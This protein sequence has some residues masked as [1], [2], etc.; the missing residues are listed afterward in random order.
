VPDQITILSENRCALSRG[1]IAE[2]GFSALVELEGFK[3]LFDTGQGMALRQNQILGYDL[4]RIDALVLS[5][6]H[7][8]HTGGIGYVLEKNPEIKIYLHPAALLKRKARKAMAGKEIEIEVGMPMSGA[9]MEALG[10]ELILIEKRRELAEGRIL[11]SGPIPFRVDF[12]KPEEGFFVEQDGRLIPDDFAD[13]LAIAVKGKK[14]DTSVIFGCAHRG[15]INTLKQIEA[16][17]GMKKLDAV[18][19]GMHLFSRSPEQVEQT[20]NELARF[21][22]HRIAVGHCTGELVQ[23]QISRR[24]PDRF[25]FP[26]PGMK[27]PLD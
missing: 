19:G 20:L 13:D 17:W 8:D 21:D 18:L 27:I 16:L 25:S 1:L 5:H 15:A 7:Y 23:M 12:E 24:F 14:G 6:G 2:H 10:A 9:E 3:L 4:S 22:P 26:A 11:I